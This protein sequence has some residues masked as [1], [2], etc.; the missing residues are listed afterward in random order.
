MAFGAVVPRIALS[1]GSIFDDDW[2]APPTPA[3]PPAPAYV[4]P[5]EPTAPARLPPAK[6]AQ[7][8]NPA[9]PDNPAPPD[10]PAP[11]PDSPVVKPPAAPMPNAPVIRERSKVP[12]DTA[13]AAAKKLVKE[14]F[15]SEYSRATTPAGQ[16]A[17][18]RA[19]FN[20]AQQTHDDPATLYALLKEARDMATAGGDAETA[21]EAA[22]GIRDAF[23]INHV[24]ADQLER[25]ALLS[26]VKTVLAAPTA[27]VASPESRQS[28]YLTMAMAERDLNAG[29]YTLAA[30][31]AGF[32]EQV[33]RKIDDPSLLDRVHGRSALLST[34]AVEHQKIKDQFTALAASPNNA[35]A[36]LAVGRFYTFVLDRPEQGMPLLA[37]GSDAA[38]KRLAE[39]EIAAS[40]TPADQL[41]LADAWASAARVNTGPTKEA[42]QRRALYWYDT[43]APLLPD[44]S[45]VAV[46]KKAFD[47]EASSL[48]HGLVGEYF[49]GRN[50]GFKVFTRVDPRV[51]FNWRGL[52]PDD[53]MP[54][55]EFSAR[56]T[57]WI[58]GSIPG[59][60]KLIF[61]HDDGARISIDGQMVVDNWGSPGHDTLSVHLTGALQE[62]KIEY[63]QF[64]GGSHI[65]LGWIPPRANSPVA[66]S[67]DALF[68]APFVAGPLA[69]SRPVP[70]GDGKI[71]LLAGNCDLH[72]P[73]NARFGQGNE[74]LNYL[75]WWEN[76]ATWLSW[77]FDAPE[78]EYDVDIEYASD[79]DSAGSRYML[80]VGGN[81]I[82]ATIA[83][84]G[85]WLNYPPT[86]LGRVRLD[87]GGQTLR[88]KC[89]DKSNRY[90]MNF[91]RIILTPVK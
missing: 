50:F 79:T 83:D 76:V 3:R 28:V 49:L 68:H 14:G 17:L 52:P 23:L 25:D 60:Y 11:S 88:V 44:S 67:S 58:K 70:D 61:V 65:G 29:N 80:S 55:I 69:A 9:Q 4:P 84:T 2:K 87:A 59:E 18:A 40:A 86:R 78:G 82:T 39:H 62:I 26:A 33:A 53:G 16:I 36:N 56:W 10:S 32:A 19:L 8:N 47:L 27:P 54:A 73:D 43:A 91:G 13:L 7:P 24:A 31:T 48:K 90:V 35:A 63:A 66:I 15:K 85:G 51:E 38:L 37:K 5:P 12:T 21:V 81:R 45:R 1:A 20:E 64:D 46:K 89:M 41:A 30:Q 22:R 42:M 77:D 75:G 72:N 6:P 74:H 34:A 71:L 57:G